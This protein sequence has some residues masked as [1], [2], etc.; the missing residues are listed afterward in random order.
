MASHQPPARAV[1]EL[2]PAQRAA[3]YVGA[4]WLLY[5]DASAGYP[6]SEMAAPCLLLAQPGTAMQVQGDREGPLDAPAILHAPGGLSRGDA[7]GRGAAFLYLDPLSAAGQ[8]LQQACGAALFRALPDG[9]TWSELGPDFETLC[10][11]TAQRGAVA[12]WVAGLRASLVAELRPTALLDRRIHRV[13]SLLADDLA[14]RLS[15]AQLAASV[16]WSPEHLRKEFREGVGMSLSRYQM[17]CRLHRMIDASCATSRRQGDLP[18][19]E[20]LL[21]DAGFY[22]A[23]HG[24]R[25][26]RRYFGLS[27]GAAL[28]PAIRRAD[29]RCA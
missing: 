7:G 12:D 8:A 5:V 19:A 28:Q 6:S 21:L 29:C 3:A 24:S 1:G 11:G 18:S 4:D 25:A 13:A 16:H 14:G 23:P 10:A 15:L 17:W 20:A 2:L 22:D 27:A 9:R 26:V